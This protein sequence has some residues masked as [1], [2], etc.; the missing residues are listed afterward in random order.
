M[1]R[2]LVTGGAGFLGSH[3]V[4][5]LLARGDEVIVLDNLRRGRREFLDLAAVRLIEADIRDPDSV[6]AASVGVETVYHLAA[7]SNVLGA[8]ADVDY[9]FSTNVV[10]TYNVLRAASE[11]GCRKVLFSSSRE[12]YG[13]Q[14]LLPVEESAQLL[15]KNPYGA[16]KVAGEAYCRAWA[17]FGT[18]ETAVL[19]FG[20]LYGPRDS[21]R[22]IPLWLQRA[23]RGEP[24][25]VY[26]GE[27]VLDFVPVGMAVEA[28][29]AASVC[30][31]DEPVNVATGV[32][33]AIL[34][35]AERIRTLSGGRSAIEVLPARGAEVVKFVGSTTRMRALLGIRPPADPLAELGA[36]VQA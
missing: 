15:A 3:L 4:D 28:L 16:S 36:M 6:S 5:A 24:L 14:D 32:G 29:L 13:E 2:V 7:Q 34:A 10:G 23:A 17:A 1:S 30:S 12:V 35:L 31:L 19:R 9:S 21:G 26:G 8:M 11:G 22:V 18:I 33:T 25:H 27:Q 20:N